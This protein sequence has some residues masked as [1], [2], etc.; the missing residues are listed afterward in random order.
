MNKA[1][2]R[3]MKDRQILQ[4]NNLN[5]EGIFIKWSDESM[6]SVK[7]LIIGP[8][9]TPYENG[10]YFFDFLFTKSYPFTP[11]KGFFKTI[12]NNV[13]FNPNLY[14]DGKI[15]LS[16]LGT[17]PGPKWS[18]CQNLRSLLLSIQTLLNEN[19]I[20]NEPGFSKENSY[21]VKKYNNI[22]SYANI[23]LATIQMIEKIP[24]NFEYF[25]PIIKLH[26][27]NNL[28]SYHNTIQNLK[29]LK[30]EPIIKSPLYNWTEYI[31]LDIMEKY[32]NTLYNKLSS[33][34][35]FYKNNEI[36]NLQNQKEK[37]NEIIKTDDVVFIQKITIS[38]FI[39]KIIEFINHYQQKNLANKSFENIIKSNKI[40]KTQ[41]KKIKKK[42]LIKICNH[43]NLELGSTVLNMRNI[44]YNYQKT[45]NNIKT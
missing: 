40:N 26:F 36:W 35:I 38:S 14:A 31:K 45:L 25:L 23:R 28:Q 19:P 37:K 27:L 21:K 39:Q 11:P 10:F 20:R 12:D 44:I 5:N 15:C 34:K 30:L 17:W 9:S 42:E 6:F 1:I 32:L 43:F 16:L 18:S 3:L 29:Q 13:R 33:E 8:K 2:K 41:L 22:V 7:A 4:K 24:K